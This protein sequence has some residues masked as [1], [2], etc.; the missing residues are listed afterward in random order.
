MSLLISEVL[1]QAFSHQVANPLFCII[2]LKSVFLKLL[3]HLPGA[4]NLKHAHSFVVCLWYA[5]EH[6]YQTSDKP[7]SQPIYFH[8]YALLSLNGLTFISMMA[9]LN[10]DCISYSTQCRLSGR[11]MCQWTGPSLVQIM[12][13]R[14]FSAKPLSQPIPVHCQLCQLAPRE[15]I[16]VKFE[17]KYD[18]FH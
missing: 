18:N 6:C 15:Q 4:N 11:Y 12:A 16:Q 17:T 8:I 3:P 1:W 14:L 5:V 7:L 13:C 9:W 10:D 2:I